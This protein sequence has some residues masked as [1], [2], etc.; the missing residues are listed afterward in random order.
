MLKR[1][2]V[3][4]RGFPVLVAHT[5]RHEWLWLARLIIMVFT[6]HLKAGMQVLV[7]PAVALHFVPQHCAR[8]AVCGGLQKNSSATVPEQ[9]ARACRALMTGPV[10][11]DRRAGRQYRSG[12]PLVAA[13]T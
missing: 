11:A 10:A 2:A 1:R 9:D 6:A 12:A 13:Q 4:A 3:D 8:L 5:A 7:T